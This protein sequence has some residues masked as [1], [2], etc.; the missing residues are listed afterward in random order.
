[1]KRTIQPIK[2]NNPKV[3]M[4]PECG[5]MY[6][7]KKS[8]DVCSRCGNPQSSCMSCSNTTQCYACKHANR[9]ID[10]TEKQINKITN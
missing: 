2:I 8:W 7:P 3:D 6:I 4:C 5:K 9:F 10:A 1:M